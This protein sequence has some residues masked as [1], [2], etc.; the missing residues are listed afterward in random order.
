MAPLLTSAKD[1]VISLSGILHRLD[2]YDLEMVAVVLKVI[3]KAD[4]ENNQ[5]PY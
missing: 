5:H 1:L 4:E 3:E 2:P